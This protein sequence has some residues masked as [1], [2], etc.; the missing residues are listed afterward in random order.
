MPTHGSGDRRQRVGTRI[1]GATCF[2][3][4]ASVGSSGAQ[5]GLAEPS[6][7]AAL[8]LG[9]GVLGGVFVA[10]AAC[11]A[12]ATWRHRAGSSTGWVVAT[13]ALVAAHAV[14]L[15]L[16]ALRTVPSGDPVGLAVLLAVALAGLPCA[17]GVLVGLPRIAPVV[18]DDVGIGL[19]LGLVA[20]GHL[21]LQLP[22]PAPGAP[23]VV[24]GVVLGVVISTHVV[25]TSVVLRQGSLSR[26]TA[27]LLAATT[28]TV[29]A[30]LVVH[31]AGSSGTVVDAVV[32]VTRAGVGA[33]WLTLA[34]VSIRRALEEDRRRLETLQQ[35]LTATSRDQRERLHELRSTLA[36]LVSG[37]AMIDRPDV[38]PETRE[39]LWGSVRRELDRMER[40]LSQQ[41]RPATD[42][43]LDE[44]LGLILD[45]QRLKGRHVELRSNGDVVRA[46]FDAL[47]EVLNILLDNA[48]THGHTARSR[49]EVVRRDDRTVDIRVTDFGRGIPQE[50][51]S[52][53]FAWGGRGSDSR[54]EGIGLSLARRLMTE[55]G[56]SLRL[57]DDQH[58]GSS[59]VIS[60][61]AARRSVE[62]ESTSE[63]RRAWL[64]SG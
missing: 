20:V 15:T 31:S 38:P 48:V 50:Q 49:V 51:R 11:A 53:I 52:Q 17:A 46:R 62:D 34:W 54:G 28:V 6:A 37:S 33:A 32:A 18:D 13:G 4:L 30:G 35:V 60:L 41:E 27:A 55:D 24:V 8:P 57:A 9:D 5:L 45:L 64:R 61:P 44:A 29:G 58:G 19:G 59:F 12:M 42:I 22:D 36:G 43:D 14:V 63:A 2:A 10:G 56:G 26:P 23:Q 39:R 40:L 25:I 1:W 7:S 47:S 3:V 16:L 21:L